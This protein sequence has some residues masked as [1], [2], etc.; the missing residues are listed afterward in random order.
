MSRKEVT[1]KVI[2]CVA[3]ERKIEHAMFTFNESVK[4][5]CES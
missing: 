1:L 3:K 2:S 4:V 5:K